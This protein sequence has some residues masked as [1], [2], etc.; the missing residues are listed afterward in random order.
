MTRVLTV[1]SREKVYGQITLGETKRMQRA[2]AIELTG[3][4]RAKALQKN[5]VLERTY[6]ENFDAIV[7]FLKSRAHDH[8]TAQ[9]IA[10]EAFLRF[11]IYEQRAAINDPKAMLFRIA[12]NA[13]TDYFRQHARQRDALIQQQH[14]LAIAEQAAPCREDEAS[15][16]D[17][18]CE[19]K[20][21]IETLPA[22]RRDV[23]LLSV[24][25]KYTNRQIAAKLGVSEGCV[26]QHYSRALRDCR[27]ALAGDEA[28]SAN[29]TRTGS[30]N[31]PK[32]NGRNGHKI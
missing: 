12:L 23:L 21:V 9:D 16:E 10:H 24:F 13:E 31:K 18:L 8:A 6:S 7:R 27:K 32:L 1:K 4:S 28:T 17:R 11:A 29:E 22:K 3:V 5:S 25:Y 2:A 30:E 20:K 15:F 26:R 19:V 14:E